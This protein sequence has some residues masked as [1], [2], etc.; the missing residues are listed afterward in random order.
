MHG[1]KVNPSDRPQTA[2]V[3]VRG[4][5]QSPKA[6]RSHTVIILL[7]DKDVKAGWP[8]RLQSRGRRRLMPFAT[9]PNE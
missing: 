5:D 1:N 2:I 8:L 4:P 6:G 9:A 7:A 3:Y